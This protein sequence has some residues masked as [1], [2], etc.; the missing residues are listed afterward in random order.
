MTKTHFKKRSYKSCGHLEILAGESQQ[1]HS[2][3]YHQSNTKI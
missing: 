1:R 2:H 3:Q